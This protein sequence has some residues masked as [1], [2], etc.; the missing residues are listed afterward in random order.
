MISSL[1]YRVF[2]ADLCHKVSDEG[3]VGVQLLQAL[4]DV[5]DDGQDVPAAQQVNHPVQ[6][7]LLQLQLRGHGGKRQ[8]IRTCSQNVQFLLMQYLLCY[9]LTT[10][11]LTLPMR[12][13][14]VELG[15]SD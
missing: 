11:K 9:I 6:E 8:H 3:D 15:K 4:A 12:A 5:A 1:Q 2:A 13:K 7:S 14:A 10:S